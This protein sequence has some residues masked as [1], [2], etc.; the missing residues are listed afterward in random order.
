MPYKDPEKQREYQR[1]WA[2]AN[3]YR[4][5]EKKLEWKRINAEHIKEQSKEYRQRNA[6]KIREHR[7]NRYWQRKI[8]GICTQCG[9][10]AV[11]PA[12]RC[13]ECKEKKNA[14]TKVKRQR[15]RENGLCI[16]CGCP[17]EDGYRKCMDCNAQIPKVRNE[18]E[19][20]RYPDFAEQ[21]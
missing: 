7:F 20:F 19:N 12:H 1:E 15:Y 9:K 8:R 21:F 11:Y 17:V 3:H 10:P 6:E 18:Y 16:I 2:R 14:N 5:R 4:F 13:E